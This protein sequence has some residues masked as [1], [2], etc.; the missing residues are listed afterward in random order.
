MAKDLP[1]VS[2][3][4]HVEGSFDIAVSLSAFEHFL[5]PAQ[6]LADLVNAV[7]PGG[8]ILITFGPPWLSPYGAHM[9]FFTGL[10][11][12]HL[13]FSEHVVFNVR[14]LYRDDGA[15]SYAPHL[16]KMTIRR[17]EKLIGDTGLTVER[18][19]YRS[20]KGLPFVGRIPIARELL[21]TQVTCVLLK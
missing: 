17:F 5:N 11:W 16:N 12:V 20:V 21:I 1:N 2:F 15:R 3:S 19:R 6:N 13:L 8:R 14:Q 4:T 7:R 10:P 9:Y 18:L